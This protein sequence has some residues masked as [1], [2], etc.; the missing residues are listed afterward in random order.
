MTETTLRETIERARDE[1]VRYTLSLAGRGD[2]AAVILPQ[3]IS[4]TG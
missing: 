2:R 4:K 3:R 1:N